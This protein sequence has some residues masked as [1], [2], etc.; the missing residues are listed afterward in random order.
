MG[1]KSTSNL[2]EFAEEVTRRL[3][4]HCLALKKD[5]PTQRFSQKLA[6]E[7]WPIQVWLDANSDDPR[8]EGDKMVQLRVQSLLGKFVD[9][10]TV[11]QA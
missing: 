8:V 4:E 5:Q 10:C 2:L 11:S 7:L 9:I 1:C 6:A 3:L